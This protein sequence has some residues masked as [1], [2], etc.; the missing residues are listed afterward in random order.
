M[1][2]RS[3]KEFHGCR[4][5]WEKEFWPDNGST[6]VGPFD[7]VDLWDKHENQLSN[8]IAEALIDNDAHAHLVWNDG[9]PFIEI[10]LWRVG[11]D[12]ICL[13]I[14]FLHELRRAI[15]EAKQYGDEDEMHKSFDAIK[16]LM[17]AEQ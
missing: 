9:D 10:F 17:E 4:T 16:Q 7:L 8:L 5:T 15:D 6:H 11:G 3:M 2:E 1:N 13:E 12:V 14:P